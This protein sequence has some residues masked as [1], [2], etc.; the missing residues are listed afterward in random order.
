MNTDAQ[1]QFRDAYGQVLGGMIEAT[2]IAF[3]RSPRQGA[4]VALYAATSAEIE[5]KNW[6]G[7]YLSDPVRCSL[8]SMHYP[9]VS[10]TD[11]MSL[12][13]FRLRLVKRRLKQVTLSSVITFGI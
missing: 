10:V 6:Q 11:Y 1:S 2:S 7:V 5:D 12:L 8:F 9:G 4:V 13:L 3:S